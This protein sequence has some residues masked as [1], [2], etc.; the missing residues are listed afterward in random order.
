[1]HAAHGG[2][3]L[4]ADRIL[5]SEDRSRDPLLIEA[6]TGHAGSQGLTL[7]NFGS[8]ERLPAAICPDASVYEMGIKRAAIR[9]RDE[10]RQTF[11]HRNRAALF[12]V[13]AMS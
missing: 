13:I 4:E 8:A 2:S 6:T 7:D 3:A 10:L 11:G 5:G 1:M 9:R 12:F